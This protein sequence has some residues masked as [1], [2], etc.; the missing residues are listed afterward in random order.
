[1][2]TVYWEQFWTTG[3]I[4][5]YLNYKGMV[6]CENVLNRYEKEETRESNNSDWNG[7]SSNA[8]S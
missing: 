6:I 3:K 8:N 4:E 2:Q 5:D 7:A 1:M